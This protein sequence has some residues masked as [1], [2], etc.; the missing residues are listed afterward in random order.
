MNLIRLSFIQ[1]FILKGPPIFVTSSACASPEKLDPKLEAQDNDN[2]RNLCFLDIGCGGGILAEVLERLLNPMVTGNKL[3]YINTTIEKLPKELR[4]QPNKFD[5]V[6]LVEVIEHVPRPS[7]FLKA[8]M[9]L[10]LSTMARAWA[11]FFEDKHINVEELRE[12]FE[13]T[14]GWGDVREVEQYFVSQP[15]RL[16]GIQSSPQAAAATSQH[17]R[18][19][20]LWRFTAIH[21]YRRTAFPAW[22]K[23][24]LL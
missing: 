23:T 10:V 24:A 12:F 13:E 5:I 22:L 7:S 3:R 9:E 4:G 11:S 8:V 20:L 16:W 21:S 17:L 19:I 2:P 1:P 15:S 6:T 18:T 14:E